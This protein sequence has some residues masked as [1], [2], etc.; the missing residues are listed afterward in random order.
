MSRPLLAPVTALTIVLLSA[1]G[2]GGRSG[3]AQGQ[4]P[5]AALPQVAETP[6]QVTERIVAAM[7]VKDWM[8]IARLMHPAALR[9]FRSLFDILIE[10][11]GTEAAD[12]RNQLFGV[13]SVEEAQALS[14]TVIFANLLR[15]FMEQT[16]EMEDVLATAEVKILGHV[17][18]GRDTVHVV[19]RM[20][21]AAD[22]IPISI[23]DVA[24]LTRF[25]N[26]WRALLKG[27]LKAIA[28]GIR[29]ALTRES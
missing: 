11:P 6:E 27:D 28:A 21:L 23:M 18:E 13:P 10:A 12:A 24:S 25:N 29:Q 26:G 9:E 5:A 14:D 1:P 3:A 16:G 8:G 17:A 20:S 15:S 7:K 4:E 19:Y 22:N 2:A